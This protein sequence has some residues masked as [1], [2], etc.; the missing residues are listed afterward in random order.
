MDLPAIADQCH[1][2]V[3]LE[4]AR[5]V[6]DLF[7]RIDNQCGVSSGANAGIVHALCRRSCEQEREDENH[8][9]NSSNGRSLFGSDPNR[10]T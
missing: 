7:D 8:S 9:T 10:S 1:E 2:N 4:V 5:F 6:V 3:M